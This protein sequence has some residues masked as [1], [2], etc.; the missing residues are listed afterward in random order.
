MTSVINFINTGT[1]ANAGNGDSLRTAFNK[2]NANFTAL[3]NSYIQSG[4]T[5]FNGQGGIITFTAT[6]IASVLGYVPYSAANPNGYVTSATVA[7]FANLDYVNSN[8]VTTATGATFATRTYVDITLTQ[9]PTLQFLTNARYANASN[10][11]TF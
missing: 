10:I 6:E 1:S 3:E 9:Y 4:V 2:I 7:G 5:S 11:S 8:F